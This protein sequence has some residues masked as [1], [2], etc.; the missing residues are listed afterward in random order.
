VLDYSA[1]LWER[2]PRA[3]VEGV[4]ALLEAAVA[5]PGLRLGALPLVPPAGRS[6]LLGELAVV[7]TEYPRDAGIAELF[8]G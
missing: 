7:R 2:A 6:A 5:D 4:D 8:A 3:L 1:D